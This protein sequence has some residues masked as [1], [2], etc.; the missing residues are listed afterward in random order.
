[1]IGPSTTAQLDAVLQAAVD[2]QAAGRFEE[3]L[4]LLGEIHAQRPVYRNSRFLAGFAYQRLNDKPRALAEY[5]L[6]GLYSPEYANTYVNRG[7]LYLDQKDAVQALA[8][9]EQAARLLPGDK[10]VTWGLQEARRKTAS[11]AH[12]R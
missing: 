8:Q 10:N 7:Y 6:A 3:S 4:T 12:D 9:F 1:M 2:A 11:S 5:D